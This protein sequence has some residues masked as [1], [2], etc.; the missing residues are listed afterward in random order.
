MASTIRGRTT[1]KSNK[2]SFARR[3]RPE[4]EAKPLRVV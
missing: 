2:G 4:A 3:R 1:A